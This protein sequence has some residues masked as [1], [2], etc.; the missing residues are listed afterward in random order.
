[1]AKSNLTKKK[2]WIIFGGG[3][4][5]LTIFI[6]ASLGKDN[7][8]AI[9]IEAE[10]VSMQ[11]VIQKVNAS[12]RIQPEIEVK[13]SATSSAWID[14]ITVKEGD[15]VKKGQHLIS[16]D[17]KQLLAIYNSATSSVR[18]AQARIKQELAS[19]KRVESMYEQNLAS[20]QELEAVEA[21]Y[22]IANSQLAQAQAN[23]ESRKDDLDK[24]RI[25]APQDGVV[26]K[27]YKEIGEMAVGGM[28]Q[29]D[30]LMIIADLSKME[31]I[32]DVNENDVVS[33][34]VGDTTEI[35]IDAFLDTLFYGVVSEIAH[36]S[37]ITGMGSQQ[38]VTNFEV[39]VRML[40]VPYGIRPG[41]SA[42]ADI[43]TDK[44]DNVL[45]IPIQSLTVRQKGSENFISKGKKSKRPNDNNSGNPKKKEMEELVF[46]LADSEGHVIR[47]EKSNK[48]ELKEDFKKAKKGTKYVH[49]R[50]VKVGI[51]SDTHYEL[52]DGLDEGE[53]IVIGPYKAI[54]K[55]LSH[56]KIVTTGKDDNDSKD[57]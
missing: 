2:K 16:L 6:I 13:I 9:S 54:S 10:K 34:E 17:R 23:L 7:S 44:K 38:Q 21:S 29:A 3:G 46:V 42:T 8:N 18:S 30:N 51:S 41:M 43:I 1:L 15:R 53:E 57:E 11:T 40:N 36:I 49:I 39:K 35:E 4:L 32:I 24:A 20:D 48:E 52:L 45:A 37:E 31:V 12:G 28:F 50:P 33:V 14:S 5:L 19:K 22:E 47:D 26:T 55:D 27:V 25:M 56:N